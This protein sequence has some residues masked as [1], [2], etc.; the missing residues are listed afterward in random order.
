[1]TRLFKK[2]KSNLTSLDNQPIS[3]AA[4]IIIL[5]LDIFILTSIF[6]GLDEHTR[7]LSS[8]DDFIPYACREMVINRHWNPSNRIENLSNIILSYSN[9]YYQIEE[10]KK[11]RHPV[12]A[13]YL[14]LLDEIK[15]N[16]VLTVVF[17][18]RNKFVHESRDLQRDI[19]N[20]KG[21]YDTS[22][23]ETIAKQQEGQ[24]NVDALKRDI[25]QKTDALNTVRSQIEGLEQKIEGNEKIRLLWQKLEGLQE[26]DREKLKEDL[27]KMYFWHPV[28]RLAM[29][30]IF[31]L[32]LVIIFYVW[33]SAS[34]R[35]NHG[36]QTL[37]SSHLLAVASIPILFRIADTIYDVIPKTLLK[38]LIDLLVSLKLVALWHYL[39]IALS[40]AAALFLIYLFQKKLFS[41]EKLI[42]RRISKGQCQQCGKHLPVGSQACP[43]CGFLQFKPCARCGRPA[44]VNAKFCREC[45][46][47]L[48]S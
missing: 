12:C 17:E 20:L 40:V 30:M 16:K 46:T 47:N 39:V 5:L 10:K 19:N 28:K 27:R 48:Q 2:I 24:A 42:E 11:D 41:R 33:N 7:Q 14:N 31:L 9:S 45:G 1:M 29:Q 6:N 32:P 26:A 18:D 43:F 37:V 13:P 35:K 25:R 44:H 34:I 15:N 8:P 22:L 38:K 23:L 3:K 4:L 21:A 36:I